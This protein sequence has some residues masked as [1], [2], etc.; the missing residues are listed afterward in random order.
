MVG[1]IKQNKHEQAIGHPWRY[2][3]PFYKLCMRAMKD[4][5]DATTYE[6]CLKIAQKLVDRFLAED[7]V[8]NVA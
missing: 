2:Q 8:C 6:A 1:L 4:Q 7:S 3:D 5:P